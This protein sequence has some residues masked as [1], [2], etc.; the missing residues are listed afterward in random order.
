MNSTSLRHI[1]YELAEAGRT[2]ALHV[3]G[4]PGGVLYLVAGQI[5]HAESPACPGVGERLV[6]S[7][8][9]PAG[10]SIEDGHVSRPELASRCLAAAGEATRAVLRGDNATVRFVEGERHLLGLIWAARPPHRARRSTLR[11]AS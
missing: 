9:I 5:T 8:R 4:S 2:G 3:G 7:G 10:G 6:A 11:P 1:L